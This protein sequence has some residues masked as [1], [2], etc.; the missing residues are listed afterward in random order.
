MKSLILVLSMCVLA[1]GMVYGNYN[2]AKKAVR[3]QNWETALDKATCEPCLN[4]LENPAIC[5]VAPTGFGT[6]TCVNQDEDQV[7]AAADGTEDCQ[8]LYRQIP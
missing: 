1:G 6:C 7:P 4:L 3:S 2:P 8:T 5:D